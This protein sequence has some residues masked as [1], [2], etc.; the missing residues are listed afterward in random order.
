[1]TDRCAHPACKCLVARDAHSV[2]TAANIARRRRSCPS[3][4]ATASIHRAASTPPRSTDLIDADPVYADRNSG[5]GR[6]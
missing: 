3:C 1:M 4:A 2:S 5:G 6:A